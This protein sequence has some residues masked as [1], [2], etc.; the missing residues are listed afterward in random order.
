MRRTLGIVSLILGAFALLL[1]LLAKPVIYPS[2]TKVAL[3]QDSTSISRGENMQALKVSAEGVEKLDGVTLLSTRRVVGI[4]G[5]AEGNNAFWQ[6]TVR[7]EVEDGPLL[8]LSD[9]GVSF[10]RTTA[11][12]TNCCGDYI[13]VGDAEAPEEEAEREAIQH[14]G[15]FFKFP[16]DTQQ[17]DYPYWDGSLGR[18]VT[19]EFQGEETIEGVSA[20]K[21]VMM[22]GPE[23]VSESQGLPGALFGTDEPVEAA[24]IYENTRTVWVEPNTGVIL[25]GLEEQNVHFAP[26]DT[27]L[28]TV[29]I[30]V[31]TI[32]YTDETVAANADEFGSSGSML[33][34]IRDRL[35]WIGLVAG[36]AL[37]A[38]GA[39]LTLGGSRS[40]RA[41]GGYEDG[42]EDGYGEVDDDEAGY[43]E[44]GYDRE[45]D[46]G[47]DTAAHDGE[48]DS[49]LLTRRMHRERDSR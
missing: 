36:L 42:Y 23:E 16:F 22:M 17:E 48:G 34:L 20:Y 10:D 28:P 31:G 32:G 37:L 8:T 44:A 15:L 27:S 6:T 2:L 9:E 24:R 18:A 41:A 14:D 35:T 46:S 25:K 43:S 7:S 33:A 38:L 47:Y 40:P 12:A 30:T 19:A 45:D 49:E 21:F 26:R 3:D 4:P 13:A 29:P 1:G 11:L 5:L 39:F